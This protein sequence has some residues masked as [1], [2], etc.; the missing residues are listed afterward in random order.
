MPDCIFIAD[1]VLSSSHISS[2]SS[3]AGEKW[4]Q[5]EPASANQGAFR[6]SVDTDAINN[7]TLSETSTS[8]GAGDGSTVVCSG[9]DR[10]GDAF[11]VGATCY[12]T[13]GAAAS[14]TAVVTAWG[15]ATA[16]LTVS[17][18]FSAQIVSGVSFI[19]EITYLDCDF[20]V[21]LTAGGDAGDAAFR[22]SH[23]GG[24]TWLGRHDPATAGAIG[25]VTVE[26]SGNLFNSGISLVQCADGSL[27]AV[28]THNAGV[29]VRKSTDQGAT[30]S[31]AT[32][33]TASH[34]THCALALSSGR[35]LIVASSSILWY[36]DDDGATWN[37]AAGPSLAR[38]ACIELWDGRLLV[39]YPSGTDAVC[40]ISADGGST[41][42]A[43][44]TIASMG[45]STAYGVSLVQVPSGSV[46]AAY[47]CDTD[48]GGNDEIKCRISDDAG[49]TWSSP[50]NVL[51]YVAADIRYPSL[52]SDMDGR[53]VCYAYKAGTG[54][55]CGVST[56]R[57]ASWGSEVNLSLSAAGQI[58]A[59]WVDGHE[60]HI[61][62]VDGSVNLL[63]ERAGY[64][65]EYSANACPVPM[66]LS[67][68]VLLCDA[69]FSFLGGAGIAGDQWTFAAGA[70]F[71]G[72]NILTESVSEPWRTTTQNVSG[73]IVF[74]MGAN[75]RLFADAVAFFGCNVRTLSI[76]ANAT[77]VWT[78]PSLD[79]ALSF[80]L[81]TGAI[82]A[83]SG[84]H[85]KDTSL[86]AGFADHE[87]V[88]VFFRATSGTDN[89]KT[90]LISDN[91]GDY[92]VLS[93]TAA[94]NLAGSDTFAIFSDK[95][96]KTFT[97]GVYRFWRIA[98]SVQQTADGYF[99]VGGLV[100]GRGV[101]GNYV[102]SSGYTLSRAYD[103]EIMRTP[104]WGLHAVHG[105]GSRLEWSIT[106]A[107]ED[108]DALGALFDLAQGRN[109]A[110][111]PN[112]S[113]SQ[114]VWPVKLSQTI[115]QRNRYGNFFD[116][117]VQLTEA[118]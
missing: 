72:E 34:L 8:D 44:V 113:V 5:P 61:L 41:W 38:P 21:E 16:A 22:W 105:A 30:W 56:D 25:A 31:A 43:A 112:A 79:E 12:I 49:A 90:W 37:Q 96:A 26:N 74:D 82:D 52:L 77:D 83:V 15:Q 101:S 23:D 2:V 20:V 60:V 102:F 32:A 88:G 24:T 28:Y 69:A 68:P 81:A 29:C 75:A 87:L 55:V 99:S 80:D 6:P 73:A 33:L 64:W 118:K 53:L 106:W 51:S 100:L 67:A 66:S 71:P 36:S 93:T 1:K 104:S 89:G 78:A 40:R 59:G 9:L 115:G 7:M 10:Y 116:I 58:G 108:Q 84:N 42:S 19:L 103:V 11:I 4:D 35:V 48:A 91:V 3:E 14:E 85:I 45:G 86:L 97:G 50:V 57:G 92:I 76:Q 94:H 111:L 17:P 107:A 114:N 110:F 98:I 46:V 13:S 54:A 117:S 65:A 27:L 95:C 63:S 18:A 39:A 70:E 47:C 109:M 62:Y